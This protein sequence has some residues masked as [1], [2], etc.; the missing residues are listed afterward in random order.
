VANIF[1][2]IWEMED[3]RG[4][5]LFTLGM[6]AVYR[7]GIFIPAPGI[8]R[9]VLGEWF[10][11]QQ[12][13]LFGLYN[14]F[15]GG[16]LEQFSVFVLGIMPYI[17]ASIIMQ[18]MAEMVPTLK[19]IKDEG[20]SGRNR[21][22]QYTRYMTIGIAVVQS[23]AMSVSMEQM[24]HLSSNVVIDPG[25]GFRLL[26]V[27]TMTGGACF[28]MWL[29]EQMTERGIGNGASIIITC[30]IVAAMPAGAAQL[31]SLIQLGEMN[32]LKGSLLLVFMFMVIFGI[33]YIER[34]QRRIPLQYAKRVLGRRVYEGQTTYLPLKVNIAGVIP[35][36]FAS[37]L[38]MFPSTL[39]QF[40]NASIIQWISGAFYPGRWLYNLVFGA[41][42]IFFAFFYTA[43]T[44]NPEDVAENLKKQGGY[45]PKV[46]P[47]KETTAYLDWLLT[48][49][50]TGGA[51]YL[52]AVC[53][54]PTVLI[55]SFNVPFYFGG[56]GLLII[57]GV[58]LDTVAQVEAQLAT[59]HYDG[60]IATKS[61]RIKGR[62]Q[63]L[64]GQGPWL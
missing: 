35:P 45:I 20:Q 48:R 14:M 18:L 23:F 57:V 56:T 32:L 28:V 59:K 27:L 21:I 44:F 9:I 64:G 41:L 50:T 40:Y 1:T 25:W 13:S 51:L 61:G 12:N 55:S 19:R 17:T 49:L 38:L 26:T 2:E 6:L 24:R 43:I 42:I 15:S 47:G 30:G 52:S 4:R 10:G 31:L 11:A 33:V 16:A 60:A 37:S 5:V 7:L 36:I 39:S 34:G 53:I 22:T 46:R 54:L 3:L 8:D 63:Q 29:G 58:T 62:R